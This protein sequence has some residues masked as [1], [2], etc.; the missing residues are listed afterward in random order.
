[1]FIVWYVVLSCIVLCCKTNTMFGF[2][3]VL[4]NI[5]HFLFLNSI[6]GV[7]LVDQKLFVLANTIQKLV[8]KS[9]IGGIK[10]KYKNNPTQ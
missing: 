6:G 1:M 8:K 9:L 4:Y 5:I 10:I 3:I 2:P 7:L